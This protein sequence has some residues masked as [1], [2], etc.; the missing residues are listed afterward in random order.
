[1][2]ERKDG[3]HARM[4]RAVPECWAMQGDHHP[5]FTPAGGGGDAGREVPLGAV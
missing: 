2:T 3:G 4:R 1:M 5:V